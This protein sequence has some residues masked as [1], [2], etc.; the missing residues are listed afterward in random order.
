MARDSI[1]MTEAVPRIA[2]MDQFRGLTILGM[3]AVHYSGHFN[4]GVAL[5][6]IFGHHGF[7]LS[8]GDLFFPWFQ[9]AAGFSLRLALL[10]R[11]ATRGPVA[12]YG[13]TVRRCLL[14][15]PLSLFYYGRL[16]QWES[17]AGASALARVAA[18]LK[19]DAWGILAIIGITS[20]W[21]L[22]V[23]GRS[24]RVRVAFVLGSAAAH[25]L[26]CQLFY[27]DFVYGRPN[28]VDALLGTIGVGGREGGPLGFLGWG[29]VQL[30]GSLV[31]DLVSGGDC[32][33]AVRVL[34]GWSAVLML[35]G[36]ALHCLSTLY[37]PVPSAG[38]EGRVAE[39]PVVPPAVIEG[40]SDA[41]LSLAPP[42]FVRP[43]EEVQRPVNYWIMSRRLGTPPFHLFATGLALGVYALFVRLSDAGSFRFGVLRTFGLNPLAAYFLDG[44]MGGIVAGFWPEGGGWPWAMA[45]ASLTFAL[46]YLPVRLMEA[47]RIFLRL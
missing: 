9:F 33:R 1:P 45:G 40:T 32:R 14:L 4:W 37:P 5:S 27:V 15:V 7:Y 34:L 3:I 29:C 25:V 6:P 19:F 47:R 26:L 18:F 46:T 28:R 39:S 41:R 8:V 38:Q 23:V 30:A 10:R 20:L 16:T 36:Y 12:A 43:R 31:Y 42:P 21:I 2:S 35:A 22:P 17:Q 24:A 11:L 44:T 13:R